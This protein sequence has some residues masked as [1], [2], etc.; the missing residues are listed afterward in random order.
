[1]NKD[2]Q[3]GMLYLLH[4]LTGV[5]GNIN[6]TEILALDK[7]KHNEGITEETILEFENTIKMLKERDIYQRAI[8]YINACSREEKLKTFAS[9]YKMSEVDGRVH[10]KEIRLLL[11]S[12]E[13]AGIEFDDVVNAAKKSSP[14]L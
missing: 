13:M 11:Y 12:I 6:E 8:E 14:L 1:M 2:Y 3:L 9:L 7:I 5:D 10:V 4:L